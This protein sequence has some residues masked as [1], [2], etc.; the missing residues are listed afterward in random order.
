MAYCVEPYQRVDFFL[1]DAICNLSRHHH[2]GL[3]NAVRCR[4]PSTR[5]TPDTQE[6]PRATLIHTP[7]RSRHRAR[8]DVHIRVQR[9]LEFDLENIRAGFKRIRL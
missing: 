7:R 3:A 1:L 8:D 2:P 9:V 6:R 5:T 4:C